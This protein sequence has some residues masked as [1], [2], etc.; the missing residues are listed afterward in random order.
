MPGCSQ[1]L[2]RLEHTWG[3]GPSR[4]TLWDSNQPPLNT[5][6]FR[7]AGSTT[8]PSPTHCTNFPGNFNGSY[9]RDFSLAVRIASMADHLYLHITMGQWTHLCSHFDVTQEVHCEISLC[10]TTWQVLF[11][12]WK[13]LY[14]LVNSLLRFPITLFSWGIAAFLNAAEIQYYVVRYIICEVLN[15]V[16]R[17]QCLPILACSGRSAAEMAATR[18]R[19]SMNLTIASLLWAVVMKWKCVLGACYLFAAH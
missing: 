3:W 7:G 11:T 6:V 2:G 9:N 5:C 8:E 1:F 19:A 18:V 15:Q 10:K 17:W 12:V 16:L 14:E 13:A 4:R